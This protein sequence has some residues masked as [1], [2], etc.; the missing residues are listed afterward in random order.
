MPAAVS[1]SHG[2]QI[3]AV[4]HEFV[5]FEEAGRYHEIGELSNGSL[6]VLLPSAQDENSVAGQQ[7]IHVQRFKLADIAAVIREAAAFQ[8]QQS[9]FAGLK[10]YIAGDEAAAA[11]ILEQEAG[12][13]L[14]VTGRGDDA[15]LQ[16]ADGD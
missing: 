16:V 8:I 10:H 14:G 12:G 13:I 4:P 2:F 9:D 7:E 15:Q 3:F 5:F 11:V 1:D 6:D